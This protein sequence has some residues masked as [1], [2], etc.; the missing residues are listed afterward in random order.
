M[1]RDPTDSS[2][3]QSEAEPENQKDFTNSAD[4]LM[5]KAGSILGTAASNAKQVA[6]ATAELGARQ[7][8]LIQVRSKIKKLNHEIEFRIPRDVGARAMQ[9]QVRLDSCKEVIKNLRVKQK[10]FDVANQAAISGDKDKQKE[11]KELAIS[12]APMQAEP[13]SYT[14]LTLPTNREV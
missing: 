14:H 8:E 3:K 5:G 7:K 11:A 12:I 9:E 2:K 1:S 10:E 4:G 6:I 13:V